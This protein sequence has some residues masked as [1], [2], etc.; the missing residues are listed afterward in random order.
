[1]DIAL[2]IVFGVLSVLI[3]LDVIDIIKRRRK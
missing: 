3:V 2:W 1:M